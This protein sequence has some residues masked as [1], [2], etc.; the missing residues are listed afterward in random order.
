MQFALPP[1]NTPHA[2]PYARASRSSPVR[3]KQLQFGALIACAVIAIIYLTT[4]FFSASEERGPSG[5]PEIVVVTVLDQA[6]MSDEYRD[7]IKENRKY[8]ANKQGRYLKLD[9]R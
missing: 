9:D 8:Y 4:R 1:R 7:R 3:R 5:T 6:T 2:P